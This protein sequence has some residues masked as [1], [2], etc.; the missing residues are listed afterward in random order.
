MD[1]IISRVKHLTN[2]NQWKSTT[3]AIN[4]FKSIK[5]KQNCSFMV[6]DIVEFYASISVQLLKNAINFARQFTTISQED[7]SIIFHSRKS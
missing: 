7:E 5:D 3:D 2:V 1:K 4:W 6:F